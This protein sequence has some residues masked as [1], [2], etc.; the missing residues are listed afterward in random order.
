MYN[1]MPFGLGNGLPTFIAFIHNVDSTWKSLACQCSITID[2]DANTNIIVDNILSYAKM[3]SIVLLYM[4]C[5]LWLAPQNFSLSLKKLHTFLKHYEF[6]GVGICPESNCPAMS[7]LQL[8]QHWP[9][10][11]IV[12]NVAK[13]FGFIQFYSRFIPNFEVSILLLCD[14]LQNDYTLPI[15][16]S[17]TSVASAAFKERHGTILADPC[18]WGYDHHKLLVPRTNV[19]DNRFGYVACQPADDEVLLS[20]VHHCMQDEGF[21]FMSKIW[22]QY[23]TMSCLGADAPSITKSDCTTI[24][25]RVSPAI[26]P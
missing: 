9:W 7:K 16:N 26:E 2:K 5:Q 20:A 25:V 4:D 13:F 8:L 6:V 11:V 1:V 12:R 3:L 23:S 19:S 15:G 10:P 22:L 14:G 24:L 21:E 18:L 17:W